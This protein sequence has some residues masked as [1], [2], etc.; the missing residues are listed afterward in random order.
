M[1]RQTL[2]LCA[3]FTLMPVV[4]VQAGIGLAE[5][6]IKTPG[7][8]FIGNN[9]S[10]PDC[11]TCLVSRPSENSSINSKIQASHVE[12]WQYHAGYISGQAKEGFFL[13]DERRKTIQF[14]QTK[15]ELQRTIASLQLKP[16]SQSMTPQDGWNQVW[17]PILESCKRGKCGS[18]FS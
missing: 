8:S 16:M 12:W 1:I 17:Q 15:A 10:Y 14:F 6:E 7:R 9:D 5:W 3:M 11:G 18:A 13:F 4:P 2:L